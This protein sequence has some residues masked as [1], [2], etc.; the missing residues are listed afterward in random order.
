MSPE[1]LTQQTSQ[2]LSSAVSRFSDELKKL[3]TGRAHPSMLDGVMIEAYGTNMPLIQVG[4]ISTPEAQLIQITPFD[5][6]NI[7]AIATA[8]RDNQSLG[9][10]PTDDGRLIRIPIPPLNEERRRD[11]VKQLH[12]KAEEAMIIMR[13]ARQDA[14]KQGDLQKKDKT[15]GDDD[16]KRFEKQVDELMANAKIKIDQLSREKEQDVMRV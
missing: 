15:W 8:I 1:Q 7:Q 4:S 14:F 3:R 11:I 5:P 12:Q 16:H 2:K 9:L 6:G 10:N 13:Q